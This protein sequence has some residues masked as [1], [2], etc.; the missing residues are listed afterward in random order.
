MIGLMKNDLMQL[1]SGIKGGFIVV[2]LIFIGV[3]SI[4]SNVGQ[5]FSYMMIFIF[6]MFGIAAFTYEETYHW[7]RYVAALPVS[8]RQIVLA[9]YG[10]TGLCMAAGLI[11]GVILWGVSLISGTGDMTSADWMLSEVQTLVIS[12]LYIEI[13]IPVMYRFGAERGR[14]V[15]LLLFI[16]FF[17]AVSVL[18]EL[19]QEWTRWIT[20]YGITM[21]LMGAA[22]I[23][24]PVSIMLACGIRAKKEF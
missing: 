11:A 14:V 3:M 21:V 9:R 19:G 10:M 18:A 1:L 22:V 7:D 4:F 17:S 15:M 12:V 5:L 13:M 2:Y 23:L 8:N 16:I 6:V 20:V 24:L